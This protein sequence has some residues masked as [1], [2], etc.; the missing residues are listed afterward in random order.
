M[1]Y[2]IDVDPGSYD[3]TLHF[4][5]IYFGSS[6]ARV[7]GV[8]LEGEVSSCRRW[9]SSKKQVGLSQLL[10]RAKKAYQ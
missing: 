9:I 3:I 5:E 10:L 7:F 6:G 8:V 4:A 1:M 2:S